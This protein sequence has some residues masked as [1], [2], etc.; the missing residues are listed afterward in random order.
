M[1][2]REVIEEEW[3]GVL[4]FILIPMAAVF[5]IIVFGSSYE[6]NQISVFYAKPFVEKINPSEYLVTMRVEVV[7]DT[8]SIC[9]VPFL[10]NSSGYPALTLQNGFVNEVLDP[11]MVGFTNVTG[12]AVKAEVLFDQAFSNSS[13]SFARPFIAINVFAFNAPT[14]EQFNVTFVTNRSYVPVVWITTPILSN[15]LYVSKEIVIPLNG[16]PYLSTP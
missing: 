10:A 12:R 7:A 8:K 3:F 2:G 15:S 14:D 11:S 13:W 5:S 6:A 16:T 9:I 1:P 4:M